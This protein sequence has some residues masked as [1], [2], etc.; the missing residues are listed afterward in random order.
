MADETKRQIDEGIALAKKV[1]AVR[2]L[3]TT[4]EANIKQWRDTTVKVIQEEINEW[5]Q[6]K[7]MAIGEAKAAERK[8]D[9]LRKSL[10]D[11]LALLEELKNL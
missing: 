3:K 4:Q 9:E 7:D 1:D 10:Q 5:V 2:E 8:R 6:K 11:K